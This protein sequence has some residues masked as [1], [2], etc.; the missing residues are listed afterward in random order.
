MEQVWPALAA[1]LLRHAPDNSFLLAHRA[2]WF[3]NGQYMWA[4]SMTTGAVTYV[5]VSLL[6]CREPFNLQRLLHR[7][8]YARPD[9]ATVSTH[10]SGRIE[11]W[12]RI[13]F[14]FDENFTRG[15]RVLA[16]CV[17]AWSALLFALFAGAV[18]WNLIRPW[19]D[20]WWAAYSWYTGVVL[21][22][23]MGTVTS[24]WLAIGGVLDLR[25]MFHRLATLERNALDDGRVVGHPNA[26]DD[27]AVA[28][29][30]VSPSHLAYDGRCAEPASSPPALPVRASD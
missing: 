23:A 7:G 9:D 19:P 5:T 11:R 14:G 29:G 4:L 15:D 12:K 24:V 28:A 18:L 30:A 10:H 22:L 2:H 20:S 6:T 26:A 8:P 17:F 16:V 13:A 21:I 3:I 27:A 25:K 1:M